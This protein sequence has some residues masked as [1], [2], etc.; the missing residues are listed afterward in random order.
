LS[1]SVTLFIELSLN[2]DGLGNVIC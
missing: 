1:I 2:Y